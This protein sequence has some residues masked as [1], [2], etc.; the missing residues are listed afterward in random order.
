MTSK[1]EQVRSCM[2]EMLKVYLDPVL[3]PHGFERGPKSMVYRRKLDQTHQE[4]DFTPAVSP[5]YRPGAE[6]HINASFTVR[7]P[8]VGE[9]ARGFVDQKALGW[10]GPECALDEVIGQPLAFCSPNREDHSAAQKWYAA[11]PDDYRGLGPVIG[12]FVEAHVIALL[13][14]IRGPKDFIRLYENKDP[15]ILI[16]KD[17]W[18]LVAAAYRV[19]G[20][21]IKA[22]DT[23]YKYFGQPWRLERFPEMYEKVGRP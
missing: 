8:Q 20:N 19:I 11:V 21:Y 9:E 15:R 3:L 23:L 14:E 16:A 2:R 10:Q 18:V 5:R 13:N 12:S 7:M 22:R 1:K 17:H 6:A 4:I